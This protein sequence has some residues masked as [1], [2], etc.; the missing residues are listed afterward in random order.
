MHQAI[1]TLEEN[2]FQNYLSL[3]NSYG[4][5]EVKIVYLPLPIVIST[6]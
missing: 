5:C 2:Y 6:T 1:D 3:I 4:G